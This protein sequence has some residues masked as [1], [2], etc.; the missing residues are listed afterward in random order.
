MA[1]VSQLEQ[2]GPVKPSVGIE[3]GG[4]IPEIFC[5]PG[6]RVEPRSG[7]K[8]DAAIGGYLNPVLRGNR[9]ISR[10]GSIYRHRWFDGIVPTPKGREVGPVEGYGVGAGSENNRKH[11]T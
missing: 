11:S 3:S 10:I 8:S 1:K 4:R 6:R 9:K 7:R 5:R 2:V